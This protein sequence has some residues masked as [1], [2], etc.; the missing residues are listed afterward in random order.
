MNGKLQYQK[1]SVDMV[2]AGSLGSQ[3]TYGNNHEFIANIEMTTPTHILSLE[4]TLAF[5]G[6]TLKTILY[7]LGMKRFQNK[8]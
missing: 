1:A 6:H 5:I 8:D 3:F 2:H 7:I 4:L